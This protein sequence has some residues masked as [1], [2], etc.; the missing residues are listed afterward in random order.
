[1]INRQETRRVYI[2]RSSVSIL[3]LQCN[4]LPT[5]S[6]FF[7]P[8][9]DLLVFP[10]PDAYPQSSLL[11]L[12][13][14]HTSPILSPTKSL[15]PMPLS[16]NQNL[17]E[18]V[19]TNLIHVILAFVCRCMNVCSIIA[20]ACFS[21]AETLR[22]FEDSQKCWENSYCFLSRLRQNFPVHVMRRV[23]EWNCT[24]THFY[25]GNTWR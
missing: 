9:L 14:T 13:W 10:A 24:S 6:I 22:S 16:G 17:P 7:I 4:I 21:K 11:L 25:F 5:A 15:K 2:L 8:L 20:Q 3:Y 18:W 23:G 1:M 19:H 12:H